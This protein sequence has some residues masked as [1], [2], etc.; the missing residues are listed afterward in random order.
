MDKFLKSL[1]NSDMGLYDSANGK[2][3]KAYKAVDLTNLTTDCKQLI[4]KYC[5]SERGPIAQLNF[6]YNKGVDMGAMVHYHLN[7]YSAKTLSRDEVF[8][9][10]A[11]CYGFNA[12][13]IAVEVYLNLVK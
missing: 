4:V 5:K 1:Q 11:N 9:S 7:E 3:L 2:S 13:E 12:Y 10:Q 8:L 6:L